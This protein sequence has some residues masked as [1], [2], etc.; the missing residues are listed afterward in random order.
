MFQIALERPDRYT[1]LSGN[2]SHTTAL[3]MYGVARITNA[4]LIHGLW[5]SDY[6]SSRPCFR[7]SRSRSF[8]YDCTL[9]F[10]K[11]GH[12]MEH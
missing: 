12:H 7:Q 10:R 11:R 4:I 9:E 8:R 6:A 3:K 5:P 1:G 2:L